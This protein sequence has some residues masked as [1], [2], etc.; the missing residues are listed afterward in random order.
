[1]IERRRRGHRLIGFAAVIKRS[2]LSCTES[3]VVSAP[4]SSILGQSSSQQVGA[5]FNLVLMAVRSTCFP[6][7]ALFA[8][9]FDFLKK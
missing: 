9:Q 7:P 3:A 1:M 4:E 2:T 8:R 5:G 6:D